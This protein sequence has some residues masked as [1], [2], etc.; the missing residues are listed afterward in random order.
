MRAQNEETR[1]E[2]EVHARA[3]Y[4][5][6][7]LHLAYV[8]GD[9]NC[10]PASVAAQLPELGI[11]HPDGHAYTDREIRAIMVAR[12]PFVLSANDEAQMTGLREDAV[13]EV[14]ASVLE[15]MSNLDIIEN[16]AERM[17]REG[18]FV[19]EVELLAAALFFDLNLELYK[20]GVREILN[21]TGSKGLL[22]IAV[23]S[24]YRHYEVV[25]AGKRTDA[26]Y[27]AGAPLRQDEVPTVRNLRVPALPRGQTPRPDNIPCEPLPSGPAEPPPSGDDADT[28]TETEVEDCDDDDEEES[29]TEG[30]SSP[31]GS[32]KPS[33]NRRATRAKNREQ[34]RAKANAGQQAARKAKA[35]RSRSQ[36]QKPS[37]PSATQAEGTSPEPAPQEEPSQ[38]S[39]AGGTTTSAG[40]CAP[41]TSGN[42][43]RPGVDGLFASPARGKSA[44]VPAPAAPTP[45]E[46]DLELLRDPDQPMARHRHPTVPQGREEEFNEAVKAGLA[47]LG[48]Y[49]S[50]SLEHKAVIIKKVMEL[51]CLVL[52]ED[53]T[54][55]HKRKKD[56]GPQHE[57]PQEDE[58]R[59]VRAARNKG[60]RGNLSRAAA[61]L[62]R[63]SAAR[64]TEAAKSKADEKMKGPASKPWARGELPK[65]DLEKE[66]KMMVSTDKLKRLVREADTGTDGGASPGVSGLSANHINV[67]MRDKQLAKLISSITTDIINGD[68]DDH[69]KV[70]LQRVYV[71][72]VSKDESGNEARPLGVVE[73]LLNMANKY[74]I[75][76]LRDPLAACMGNL[77]TGCNNGAGAIP[78]LGVRLQA[79]LD[80]NPEKIAL[81]VDFENAYGRCRRAFALEELAKLPGLRAMRR[82]A[83]WQL[84]SDSYTYVRSSPTA[85]AVRSEGAVVEGLI[86]GGVY[87]AALFCGSTIRSLRATQSACPNVAVSSVID[88]VTFVGFPAEVR[89]AYDTWFNS[90]DFWGDG[91]R[92]RPKLAARKSAVYCSSEAVA[93]SEAL[94][95]IPPE[96]SRVTGGILIGGLMLGVSQQVKQKHIKD[97]VDAASS[98]LDR[99]ERAVVGQGLSLQLSLQLL[100]SCVLPKMQFLAQS[101]H[102]RLVEEGVRPL[103]SKIRRFLETHFNQQ[104]EYSDL[105]WEQA[106]LPLRMGGL[107]LRLTSDSAVAAYYA[108]AARA[109]PALIQLGLSNS[110]SE[111]CTTGT[112]NA[113]S[114]C[115][116]KFNQRGMEPIGS[117]LPD[118]KSNALSATEV[119]DFALINNVTLNQSGTQKVVTAA[120]ENMRLAGLNAQSTPGDRARLL[121]H[122]KASIVFTT[123][124]ELQES[125]LADTHMMATVQLRLGAVRPFPEKTCN[126]RGAG[127]SEKGHYASCTHYAGLI[128]ERHNVVVGTL[129][130][131]M[132]RCGLTAW[133]EPFG[134]SK[135]G[136]ERP[137]LMAR[138][139]QREIYQGNGDA[140]K[141]NQP[142]RTG[143]ATTLV[144]V[145]I[146]A[147][148]APS[149][150]N[151][152]SL[153]NS[154]SQ[155]GYS[156]K[157]REGMKT[158]KYLGVYEAVKRGDQVFVPF[159]MENSGFLGPEAVNFIKWIATQAQTSGIEPNVKATV[160]RIVR[161][162]TMAFHKANGR[163]WEAHQ[164]RLEVLKA[165]VGA[166]RNANERLGGEQQG[167][168]S[169]STS[170]LREDED[171]SD[172]ES[173]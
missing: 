64:P 85:P 140:G 111:A 97:V 22:R 23:N 110:D 13:E 59:N 42:R 67:M 172:A 46:A 33:G 106:Q 4:N 71:E 156:A 148:D 19:S 115:A 55:R 150:V 91:L 103:E 121:S 6:K 113:L 104:R 105:Q 15:E 36:K 87:N 98:L 90:K 144:D 43:A 34:D 155:L 137:D 29:S 39:A 30:E 84:G 116:T 74:V 18:K 145:A 9:G 75:Q 96:F 31:T 8:K 163:I 149:L 128:I 165:R 48:Q 1:L 100:R 129:R 92:D 89:E 101:M 60:D 81:R 38:G 82:S 57:G 76:G 167:S 44:P 47:R 63:D 65:L 133:Q 53:A 118:C 17:A 143:I 114:Y 131:E 130:K 24:S 95:C 86:Q 107:G 68:L 5:E 45:T 120:W 160:A 141:N 88:D 152:S 78:A 124:R 41:T 49:P 102:P 99:L 166:N 25:K 157:Q 158:R 132:S 134:L 94:K 136:S 16:R 66:P 27:L 51:P 108:T 142:A 127:W 32:K 61:A 72:H 77:Q 54:V 69:A 58:A 170:S 37:P 70:A 35:K 73:V 135:S 126:C 83:W 7:M 138:M 26:D 80:K 164:L 161:E 123:T 154:S 125:R 122:S 109:A 10:G 3:Q 93:R 62:N 12:L 173:A 162:V 52:E 14:E 2:R 171:G 117:I 159:V 147:A 119:V 151:G 21:D 20:G 146:V 50:A 169:S 40:P 139:A 56:K 79:E 168:N 112:A 28:G 153:T 11:S